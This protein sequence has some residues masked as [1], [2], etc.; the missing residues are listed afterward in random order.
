MPDAA[1]NTLSPVACTTG[2]TVRGNLPIEFF[3]LIH[4][5][6]YVI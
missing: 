1:R 3:H 5:Y 2:F 6:T 4:L